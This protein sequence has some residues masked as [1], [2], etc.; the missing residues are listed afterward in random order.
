MRRVSKSRNWFFS[1]FWKSVSNLKSPSLKNSQFDF[2]CYFHCLIST[3]T[4]AVLSFTVIHLKM[5]DIINCGTNAGI[6]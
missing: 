1:F 3:A 2:H 6:R 5:S 4:F